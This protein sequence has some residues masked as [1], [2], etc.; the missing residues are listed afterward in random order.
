MIWLRHELWEYNDGLGYRLASR[1][2]GDGTGSGHRDG[3]LK[4]VFYAPS[5]AAAKAQYWALRQLGPIIPSRFE[6]DEPFTLAQ[7]QAQLVQFPDDAT[8]HAQPVLHPEQ[9]ADA[10]LAAALAA[11]LAVAEIEPLESLEPWPV[12]AHSEPA[13]AEPAAPEA[14]VAEAGPE[15]GVEA[16]A[17]EPERP[18]NVVPLRPAAAAPRPEPTEAPSTEPQSAEAVAMERPPVVASGALA[19]ALAELG[20]AAAASGALALALAELEPTPHTRPDDSDTGAGG[21]APLALVAS[22]STST[23]D[24]TRTPSPMVGD[25]DHAEVVTASD[26]ADAAPVEPVA[27]EAAE[28]APIEPDVVEPLAPEPVAASA[29]VAE[30]L[31]PEPV[32]AEKAVEP[33]PLGPITAVAAAGSRG[34]RRKTGFFGALFRLLILAIV[35]GAIIVGVG[36]AT[37]RLDGPTL[38]AQARA[39]PDQARQ[40]SVDAPAFVRNL[41]PR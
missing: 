6:S 33:D 30:P 12:V 37:G 27:V 29:E 20:P 18:S 7:L 21:G 26:A 14:V 15:A 40:L 19:L 38:L 16:A 8:L 35:A 28:V 22:H 13:P 3:V 4:H 39:L 10:P 17:E 23:L 32:A 36:I 5:P 41:L 24:E 11:S 34:K 31:V 9:D 2:D 25:A 1:S